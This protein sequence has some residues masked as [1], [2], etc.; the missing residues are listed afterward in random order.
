MKNRLRKT[1]SGIGCICMMSLMVYGCGD[2]RENYMPQQTE[3][4]AAPT[5]EKSAEKPVEEQS[6]DR[7]T[8]PESSSLEELTGDIQEIGDRTF[9][10]SEVVETEDNGAQVAVIVVD[11]DMKNLIEVHYDE[12]TKFSKR[13]IRDGGADYEDAEATSQDLAKGLLAEMK[14]MYQGEEFYASEI[15]LIQVIN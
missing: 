9:V 7:E 12:N 14:G 4:T 5:Q 3:E 15:Q 10:I 11:E 8:E 13:I 2:S 6:Q 1:I